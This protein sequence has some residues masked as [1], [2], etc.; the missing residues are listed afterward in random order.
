MRFPHRLHAV[1]FS[2]KWERER[3]TIALR[4]SQAKLGPLHWTD[5]LGPSCF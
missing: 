4:Q 5:L 3:Q 1:D 2:G